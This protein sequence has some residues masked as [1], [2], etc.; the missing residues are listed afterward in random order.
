MHGQVPL[1]AAAGSGDLAVD[2]HARV[3][4]LARLV[5]RATNVTGDGDVTLTGSVTGTLTVG[6]SRSRADGRERCAVGPADWTWSVQPSIARASRRR[7]DRRRAADRPLGRCDGRSVGH[8]ADGRP[9]ALPVEIPR[10]SGPATVTAAVRDLDP[11]VIP[12]SPAGLSGRIRGG[13]G[14]VGRASRALRQSRGASAF[15][16]SSS[17]STA[18]R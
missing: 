13:P 5:P 17:R 16:N 12:G 8:R 2:G 15:R 6:R 10:Q 11:A 3:A 18:S 14:G 9:A 1:A 7:R 4:T